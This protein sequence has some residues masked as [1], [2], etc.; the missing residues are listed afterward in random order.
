MTTLPPQPIPTTSVPHPIP[1]PEALWTREAASYLETK[2]AHRH[3]SWDRLAGE[4]SLR[5]TEISGPVLRARIYR[6]D[7][8]AGL[9]FQSMH[10]LAQ[11]QVLVV[12]VDPYACD[13]TKD[14]LPM[15]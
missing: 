11:E 13:D 10:V 1:L 2:M 3:V 14:D 7:I 4:L 9:F 5:G 8:S 6:G 15:T 12:E